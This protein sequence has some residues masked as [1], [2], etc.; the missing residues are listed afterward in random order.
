MAITELSEDERWL[1]WFNKMNEMIV[2]LNTGSVNA[3]QGQLNDYESGQIPIMFSYDD[4]LSGTAISISSGSYIDSGLFVVVASNTFVIANDQISLVY[5][6]LADSTIKSVE[7]GQE[8]SDIIPL[9][10]VSVVANVKVSVD[11]IRTP[12]LATDIM[13]GSDI[14]SIT[15]HDN[16]QGVNA[17]EHIDWTTD[18]V[19]VLVHPNNY[20]VDAYAHPSHQADSFDVDSGVLEGAEVLSV[21]DINVTTDTQGHVVD[22]NAVVETRTLTLANLGYTGENNATA[23][24]TKQDIDDLGINAQQ[25]DG[26]IGSEYGRRNDVGVYTKQ[27]YQSFPQLID[28]AII[29]WNMN[30]HPST[31]VSLAGNRILANPTNAKAGNWYTLRVYHN[32]GSR[33]LAYGSY[34]KFGGEGIPDLS[35]Q[36]NFDILSFYALSGNT[37]RF[38]GILNR[39]VSV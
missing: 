39:S 6:D 2:E 22:A 30:T 9:Y 29:N 26:R 23:D 25:L 1:D 28:S 38:A 14:E 3:V 32:G 20:S 13:S 8:S 18:Q 36:G 16:L 19:D 21:V 10:I 35:E 12:Y 17:D 11:D 27:Q 15:N 24:Q 5:V 37:I 31:T 34:F 4:T 33:Q 7:S